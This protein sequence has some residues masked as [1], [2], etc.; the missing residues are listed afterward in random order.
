MHFRL[1]L[2]AESVY[3]IA[4]IFIGI[5]A[6][7]ED[8]QLVVGMLNLYCGKVGS[9]QLKNEAESARKRLEEY[10]E[11]RNRRAPEIR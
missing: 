6:F 9:P 11:E 2:I 10:V 5:D 7:P 3:S 8:V 1:Q 4:E